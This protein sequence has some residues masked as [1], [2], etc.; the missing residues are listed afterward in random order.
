MLRPE[1]VGFQPGAT[2][3]FKGGAFAPFK[4]LQDGAVNGENALALCEPSP[5]NTP[6]L[7]DEAGNLRIVKEVIAQLLENR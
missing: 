2:V 3:N 6:F 1:N 5:D 4:L 7:C